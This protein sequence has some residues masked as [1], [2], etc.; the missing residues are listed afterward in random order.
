MCFSASASFGAS[1]TLGAIGVLSTKAAVTMPQ[2][3]FASIPFLFAIQQFAEG[4]IWLALQNPQIEMSAVWTPILKNVFLIFAWIIC[5]FFIPFVVSFLESDQKKRRLLKAMSVSGA[6]ISA[7]LIYILLV[8]DITPVIKGYHIAYERSNALPG[9]LL[10]GAI[11]IVHLLVPFFISS[12]RKLWYL[13]VTNFISL[14]IAQ[15]LFTTAFI[16]VW[17]FLAALSSALIYWLI[18]GMQR[19]ASEKDMR[20]SS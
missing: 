14:I 9:I 19:D 13:G 3:G 4:G 7:S 17:C 16:S 1:I 10:L 8:S 6:M 18:L 11:Y 12:T 5:P 2:K 15:V 20:Y